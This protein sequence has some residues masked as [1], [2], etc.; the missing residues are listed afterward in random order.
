MLSVFFRSSS[1][2]MVGTVS[3]AVLG[4]LETLVLGR[5]LGVAGFGAFSVVFVTST[6]LVALIG[7]RTPEALSRQIVISKKSNNPQEVL[8]AITA[9]IVLQCLVHLCVLVSISVTAHWL[10]IGLTDNVELQFAFIF[11]A[12]AKF[13]EFLNPVWFTVA[14]DKKRFLLIGFEPVIF[15]ALQLLLFVGLWWQ[16]E[17]TVLT[18]TIVLVFRGIIQL[19]Y[20][21]LSLRQMIL[22]TGDTTASMS[23]LPWRQAFFFRSKLPNLWH[24]LRANFV[25]SFASAMTKYADVVILG[26]FSSNA[27]VGLYRVARSIVGVGQRIKD[28][29]GNVI[30][31]GYLEMVSNQQGKRIIQYT[32]AISKI[33]L[34][35][36]CLGIGIIAL[37]AEWIIVNTIGAAF[38]EAIPVLYIFLVGGF[39]TIAFFWAP[40]LVLA[41]GEYR[42]HMILMLSVSIPAAVV[43]I[44]AAIF[45]GA[46]GIAGV[47]SAMWIVLFVSF[48]IR[49]WERCKA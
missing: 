11:A 43:Y 21:T 19:V 1:L 34:P 38:L 45:Y 25:G 23:S 4:L 6:F 10:A 32:V 8:L 12:V 26:A 9:L 31:P 35:L 28:V 30:Y 33:W 49:G 20:E 29:L 22:K 46:K 40:H 16:G 47:T 42:F 36:T 13:T 17:L 14:R 37:Q 39:V 5:F 18:S 44:P 2:L 41:F 27:E 48:M 24:F 3:A 7:F 15:R